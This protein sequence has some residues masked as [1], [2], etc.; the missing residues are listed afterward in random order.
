VWDRLPPRIRRLR[1]AFAVGCCY[2]VGLSVPVSLGLVLRSW[3]QLRLA[4]SLST[5]LILP[6][7][8]LERG[9]T[10]KYVA[11]TLGVAP[12][13]ASRI[14]STPSWR[15]TVWQRPPASAL[16]QPGAPPGAGPRRPDT[17]ATQSDTASTTRLAATQDDRANDVTR[18]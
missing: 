6:L 15:T 9:R 17:A 3:P 11:D 13:D 7:L 12:I 18:M 10:T 8:F 1:I 2:L 4:V 16:L 5:F 14:L